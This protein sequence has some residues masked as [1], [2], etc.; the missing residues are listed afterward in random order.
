MGGSPERSHFEID[1]HPAIEK[2]LPTPNLQWPELYL[3]PSVRESDDD[4]WEKGRC[5]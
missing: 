1:P 2:V 3:Q 5:L 4:A